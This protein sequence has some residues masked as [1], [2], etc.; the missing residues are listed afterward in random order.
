MI[1][2]GGVSHCNFH[3]FI[4]SYVQRVSKTEKTKQK[5]ILSY[6]Q[7]KSS[8][9]VGPIAMPNRLFFFWLLE[10]LHNTVSLDAKAKYLG[11]TGLLAPMPNLGVE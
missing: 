4:I 3:L 8:H 5:T 6:W 10:P 7:H 2:S 11:M 1:N 9:N